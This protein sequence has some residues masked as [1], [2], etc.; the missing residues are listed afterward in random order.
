MIVLLQREKYFKRK[1]RGV[2][3]VLLETTTGV[4][5]KKKCERWG[6]GNGGSCAC[7][8]GVRTYFRQEILNLLLLGFS[9]HGNQLYFSVL[10]TCFDRVFH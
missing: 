9:L 1:G 2:G 8:Y 7:N 6:N 3:D 10:I 4:E 5:R